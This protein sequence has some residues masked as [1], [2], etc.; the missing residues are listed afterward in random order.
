[1]RAEKAKDRVLSIDELVSVWK[2]LEND[3]FGDIA[4][5]LMLTGQRRSEIGD[6]RWEEISETAITLPKHRTKNGQE[7]IVP[8]SEPARVIL[9][10]QYHIVGHACVFAVR[11]DVGFTAYDRGKKALDAKLPDMAPWTLH[12]LRRSVATHL[13][14]RCGVLPHVIEACLNHVSGHKAGVAGIYNRATYLKEK[15]EALVMWG[16]YL[17]AAVSGGNAKIVTLRTIA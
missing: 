14:E 2:A 3:T 13:A 10:R 11:S 8:L 6:L 12:D 5:L 4:K 15:T 7:H 1:M 17:T 9:S 16:E